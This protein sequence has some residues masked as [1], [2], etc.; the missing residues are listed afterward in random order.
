MPFRNL[1]IF[2]YMLWN[3]IERLQR[4]RDP[5]NVIRSYKAGKARA[6]QHTG[7]FQEIVWLPN[8]LVTA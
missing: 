4:L 8:I 6:G 3:H 2:E 1:I 5:L 7:K